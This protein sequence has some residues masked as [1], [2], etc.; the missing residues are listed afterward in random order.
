MANAITFSID[1]ETNPIKILEIGAD[2][3]FLVKG[4][5]AKDATEV[6][7]AL[8]EFVD[9]W[10]LR[11]TEGE[12]LVLKSP[13][14]EALPDNFA[15]DLTFQARGEDGVVREM[16]QLRPGGD[17]AIKGEVVASIPSIYEGFVAYLRAARMSGVDV[18]G[19]D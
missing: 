19:K 9:Y 17:I 3:S 2:G 12:D 14:K 15:G 1:S 13:L 16:I 8:R 6:L 10:K 11:V 7:S 5:P 4:K 18:H